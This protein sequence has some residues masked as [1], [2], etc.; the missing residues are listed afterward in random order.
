MTDEVRGPGAPAAP[1]D[2]AHPYVVVVQEDPLDRQAMRSTL[3]D[4]YEVATV[5]DGFDLLSQVLE[6]KPD[7]IILDLVLPGIPGLE[8]I[9]ALQ[10]TG[11]D[12]PIIATVG[13]DRRA[14]D[15]L[16]ASIM[17]AAKLLRRPISNDELRKWVAAILTGECTAKRT[18]EAEDAASL[19]LDTGPS[20][21]VDNPTF[22]RLVTRSVRMDRNYDR[23]SAVALLQ[24]RT[25]SARDGV[26]SLMS[27]V[28][29][30][31]DFVTCLGSD[32]ILVLLPL[33]APEQVPAIFQRLEKS[34]E[35]NNLAERQLRCGI[36]TAERA[37]ASDCLE[38]LFDGLVPWIQMHE[39]LERNRYTA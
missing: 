18:P 11:Q 15:W 2:G 34:F 30:S 33:T 25:R 7:L 27:D 37:H 36:V 39:L 38:Y 29:R 1:G 4:R 31:G 23:R 8:V 5:G 35:E 24:A 32:Q 28:L 16:R 20:K 13:A 14:E 21:I 17:G 12:I 22:Q 6:R 19:L 9:H 10:S 26:V 3:E